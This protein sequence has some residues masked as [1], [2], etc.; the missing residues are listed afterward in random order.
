VGGVLDAQK[1]VRGRLR[2]VEA[3]L[4]GTLA[5]VVAG[6]PMNPACR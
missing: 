4:N 5:H 1:D 6:S 2:H 3:A